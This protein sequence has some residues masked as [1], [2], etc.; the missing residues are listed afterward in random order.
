MIK[1]QFFISVIIWYQFLASVRIWYQFFA[2]FAR[3]FYT[4]FSHV[5]FLYQFFSDV[6]I[7]H[8]FFARARICSDSSYLRKFDTISSHRTSSSHVKHYKNVKFEHKF[9][10]PKWSKVTVHISHLPKVTY[11]YQILHMVWNLRRDEFAVQQCSFYDKN[12]SAHRS[13]SLNASLIFVE[14]AQAHPVIRFPSIR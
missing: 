14:N 2:L 1:Y 11:W 10:T 9:N 7:W 6:R 13:L 8:R 4:N 3:V 12:Q 5:M